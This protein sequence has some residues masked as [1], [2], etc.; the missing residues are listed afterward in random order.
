MSQSTLEGKRPAAGESRAAGDTKRTVGVSATDCTA[1]CTPRQAARAQAMLHSLLN[2]HLPEGLSPEDC[3]PWREVLTELV[4]AHVV[5]GAEAVRRSF[6][7]LAK[8]HPS[9]IARIANAP[10]PRVLPKRSSFF[11]SG[12]GSFS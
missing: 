12:V 9:L 4:H 3:G 6:N 8:A 7:A 1:T 10:Q 5:G 2:G 11:C